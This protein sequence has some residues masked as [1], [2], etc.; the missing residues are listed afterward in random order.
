MNITGN[1]SAENI[2]KKF[3][4]FWHW[5]Q[6]VFTLFSLYLI[7]DVSYRWDAFKFHSS[8]AEYLPNVALASILW[9]IVAFL[10]S[11][12]VWLPMKTFEVVC[13]LAR[14][15]IKVEHLV[16]YLGIVMIMATSAW[17]GKKLIWSTFQTSFQLKL[18]VL[19][20][21][22]CIAIPLVWLL[23]SKAILWL[24]A[25][26]ER[27]K[28][29][30]WL[31]A[32]CVM[33]S[34]VLVGFHT[35]S[36]KTNKAIS[37]RIATSSISESD[38]ERPNILLVTFD[39]L[40]ARDM[41]VYGYHRETTPFITEWAKT[42]S[43]FTRTQAASN[44][45]AATTPSLMTGKRTWTHRKYHHDLAAKPFKSDTENLAL[46]MKENGYYNSAFIQNIVTPVNALGISSSVDTAPL[47]V[48]F[49]R[50]ASIEGIIEKYL[51]LL[52][53]NTFT[54]YNW[55]GQDDFI[56]T[57]LLRRIDKQVFVTEL[58]PELVF[59]KFLEIIDDNPRKPFFAWLHIMPPH[60]PQSPPKP[61]AGAFN[62]SGEL[63]GQNRQHTFNAEVV[64]HD[65][66]NLPWS[67][68]VKRKVKILRDYYDE[69]IMYCDKQFE[70]F[71]GEVEKRN[72]SKNTV[73]I[74]SSDHGESFEHD[75]FLHK[76]SHLYEQVTH[77]PLIIKEPE[78][79]AAKIINNLVEQ[80]DIPATILDLADIPVPTWMEGSSLLPLLRNGRLPAKKPIS[81]S[82]YN[83]VPTDPI[84]KGIIAVW[85]GD[86]KLI[87]YLDNKKSLLFNL[88]DDPDE[89][90]NLFDK[91]TAIGKQL[92][93]VIK[94]NLKEANK[95]IMAEK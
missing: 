92:L 58:P 57:V 28:P 50:P 71:I 76:P 85:E 30:V 26:Q 24:I 61:F 87:H 40:T 46:I 36:T 84:T 74:L 80:V 86:Y 88:K 13:R 16:L 3:F 77:I 11:T 14:L 62:P 18:T 44:Y 52:F 60:A 17:I 8:F 47:V 43:V 38:K 35:W 64:Q 75:Y 54:T 69:F 53:G 20:S 82:L 65:S 49:S 1:Q 27:I 31:F 70:N 51:F 21:I 25:I 68:E 45:T 4:T 29:L 93:S 7:G 39:T 37:E 95:R 22:F 42:A 2:D 10:S 55:L 81:V 94:N 32:I 79:T 19:I 33:L 23:R 78:Q 89:L 15:K 63:R 83:N 5:F 91:K 56:F 73:I 34:L 6:L 90:N 66:N 72:W 9:S 67:K 12:L 59:N 48:E 41:S